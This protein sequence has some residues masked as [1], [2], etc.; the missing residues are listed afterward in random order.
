MRV[1]IVKLSSLGDVVHAMPV[2]QDIRRA[3]PSA[4]IDWVVE[5]GFAPL[6]RRCEGIGRVIECELRRW[7]KQPLA[8][9][10]RR[11]FGAFKSDLQRVRYDAVLDLQGLSKSALLAWLACLAPQGRRYAMANQTEG[12][13][14][15]APTRWLANVALTLPA[16]IHALT[17]SRELSARALGYALPETMQFGLQAQSLCGK[18]AISSV[19]DQH[20][21]Q[22][23]VVAL[24]HGTSRADKLWPVANWVELARALHAQGLRVALPHGSDEEAQR[25]AEI[26]AAL[27]NATVWPRLSLDDLVDRLGACAGVIGV[28][29]GLSHIA[30]ALDLPHVQ[31]YNFDTAWRTGPLA[32]RGPLRQVSVFA[33]PAPTVPVVWQAWQQVSGAEPARIGGAP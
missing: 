17:R 5:R 21:Q 24:V 28:D 16:H 6:V 33:T 14:Y 7:R 23:G 10:T 4:R 27:P 13:G 31:V 3:L 30:V 9:E 32:G 26:A 25:A 18:D 2:V 29:S 19:A 8:S 15:E 1:L 22:G 11:A 12:S 20:G